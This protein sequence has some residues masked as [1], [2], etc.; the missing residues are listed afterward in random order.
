M[1]NQNTNR[2]MGTQSGR[3]V[4]ILVLMDNQNTPHLSKFFQIIFVLILV[5]M[6]NQNTIFKFF[7]MKATKCLNPCS[8][9]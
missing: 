8:N 3:K 9:G 5:L 2:R 7:Y 6:D 1:D 4:L